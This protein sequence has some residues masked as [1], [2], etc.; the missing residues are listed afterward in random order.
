MTLSTG[1]TPGPSTLR[2]FW[3]SRGSWWVQTI[4]K[5]DG[6]SRHSAKYF[7]LKTL[8]TL[9]VDQGAKK[10]SCNCCFRLFVFGA[11]RRACP[12]EVLGKNRLF[13]I[14]TCLF[15]TFKFLPTQG[16]MAPNH[17]P[18]SLKFAFTQQ[19][20]DYEVIAQPR[21]VGEY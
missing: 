8:G 9:S 4:P 5:G 3:M 11:G 20:K 10:F 15:Q 18:W 21:K 2:D 16:E 14:L 1:T 12:G 6:A 19:M 17:D 13:L 7:L